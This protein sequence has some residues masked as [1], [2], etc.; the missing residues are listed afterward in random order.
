MTRHIKTVTVASL[1][2][3]ILL[4]GVVLGAFCHHLTKQQEDHHMV[5]SELSAKLPENKRKLFEDTMNATW[6]DMDD[7]R[8]QIANTKKEASDILV[9]DPFNEALYTTQF[10]HI[11]ELHDKMKLRM[12]KSV[13]DLAK[14][15]TPEE[16][17]IL[18]DTISHFSP[19]T[20]PPAA[21][22]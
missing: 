8:Q 1:I 9:K 15:L 5:I 20:V 14:Q 2:L 7:T 13:T 16:R 17:V 18:A 12:A 21:K 19:N 3:N 10:Q 11:N 22:Q 4:I 6:K